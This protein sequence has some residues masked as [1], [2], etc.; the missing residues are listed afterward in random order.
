MQVH[1]HKAPQRQAHKP[2]THGPGGS[3]PSGGGPAPSDPMGG[4]KNALATEKQTDKEQEDMTMA[5]NLQK[6]CHETIMAIIAN[7]K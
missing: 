2:K 7:I 5:S 3:A 6:K 1:R 4:A